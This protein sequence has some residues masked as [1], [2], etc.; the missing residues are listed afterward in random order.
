MATIIDAL[1]LYTQAKSL[2]KSSTA[3]VSSLHTFATKRN[4]E[5]TLENLLEW[6]A[7]G[8]YKKGTRPSSSRMTFARSLVRFTNS[9]GLTSIKWPMNKMR[10]EKELVCREKMALTK[11]PVSDLLEAYIE[12][13]RS[14]NAMSDN[15]HQ[16]LRF[17]NEFCAKNYNRADKS[18]QEM[19]NAW[20]LKRDTERPS[21]FNKRIAPI[22]NFLKYINKQTDKEI[23]LP[24]YLV[25][26][27]K[28]FIPHPYTKDELHLLFEQADTLSWYDK[29]SEFAYNVRKM[30]MP[31]FLRLLYSTGMRTCEA[32]MLS[33]EDVDL[34]HGVVNIRQSKGIG[35]HRVALH[36]TMWELMKQYDI[37]INQLLPERDAFFPNEFGRY[38]PRTWESYH[39]KR[40]W[41]KVSDKPAR[42]Y[43]LRSNYAVFNIN[44]WENIGPEWFDKL[45]YLSRSMGHSTIGATTYYYNLVPIFANQIEN[46]SGD[47][48]E[49]LLPDLTSYY[50]E[51][52]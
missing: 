5:I 37:A 11:S 8:A 25:Y 43:D 15:T 29:S 21:S 24:S 19:V 7:V 44:S 17:F 1:S 26:E 18:Y 13:K 6:V 39:F 45:L 22:R 9:I 2:G 47:G 30:V 35:E 38:L 12:Y 46:L 36:Q 50:N 34:N 4:L 49:Q 28:K 23:A 40:I 33:C 42:L 48:F 31:V 51:E 27:K 14:G 10:K 32:R 41:K 16:C 20:C 3:L 52:D